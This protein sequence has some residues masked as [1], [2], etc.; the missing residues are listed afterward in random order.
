RRDLGGRARRDAARQ[1]AE[2]GRHQ[3]DGRVPVRAGRGA[4]HAEASMGAHHQRG[5]HRRLP[6]IG[7]R[8]ALRAVRRDQGRAHGAHARAR[9]VLGA[10]GDPRQRDRAWI[11]S[12]AARRRG[13]RDGGAGDQGDEPDPARG[14]RRRIEGRG[15]VPRRRRIQLHHRTDHRRRWREDDRVTLTSSSTSPYAARPWTR[16]QDYW[17]RHDL[18]YPGRPL[19]DILA[20]TAVDMPDRQATQFLGASLTFRD[21]KE[22]S[23]ALAA[24]LARLG[25]VKGDRVGIMLPNCPQYIIASFAILRLGAVVVNINPSYTARETGIVA[26]DSG[27]RV[28]LTLHP[29][30]P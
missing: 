14:R 27:V 28:V 4:R 13:H 15:R 5:V 20:L 26:A 3:P 11:F 18:P 8:S 1:V 23:D 10:Q 22:R 29:P 17:V 30:P 16:P 6:R 2:G 9:R 12:F 7:A 21:L 24:A 19:N 25:I